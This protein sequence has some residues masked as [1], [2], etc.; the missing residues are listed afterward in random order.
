M[1]GRVVRRSCGSG[2]RPRIIEVRGRRPL[3]QA[4]R[5]VQTALL[6]ALLTGQAV[7]AEFVAPFVPSP[8]EDV[9]TMLELAAVGPGDYLID[10]GSGDGRIVI[11]AALRGAMGHGV[12]L[13]R[14]LVALAERRARDA[15]VGDRVSFVQG[16]VFDADIGAAT[17]VTLYLMP[18]VNLRLRPKLLAELRPGTRVVS[19][20]FDMGEW[21]PDR[22]VPGRASGGMM[23]WIVPA[24]VDGSWRFDAGGEA[25]RA[26]ISQRFQQIEV[27]LER[28]DEPLHVLEAS[29]TGE[30][31]T[32][33][34]GD[35][36]RRYAFS[37]RVEGG[38]VEG[39]VQ[40]HD[41][42]DSRV[43]RWHGRRVAQERAPAES[44]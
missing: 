33:L 10:L 42:A 21:T 41:A 13:D 32:L 19:N 2:L 38:A 6:C 4:E 44:S 7:A 25:L 35:G 40:V 14:E 26:E 16:D 23:L 34:A 43:R 11:T 5:L 8:Q 12:E 15:E 39:L 37:G 1:T 27:T 18:E 17:V 24:S 36:Q 31:L 30:R 22:H 3:P 29:L 9:E 28:G 20:S